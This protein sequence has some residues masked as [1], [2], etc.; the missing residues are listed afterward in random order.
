MRLYNVGITAPYYIQL[1]CSNGYCAGDYSPRE[2]FDKWYTPSQ[3]TFDGFKA[4]D[5]D[6]VLYPS[7]SESVQIVLASGVI[8]S[9][10]R[11]TPFWIHDDVTPPDTFDLF[12]FHNLIIFIISF[13]ISLWLWTS[14]M[15]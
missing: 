1:F 13:I 14:F 10:F 8:G 6:F 5:Y 3:S 11:I 12:L 2:Y 9:A 7:N 4:N 15:V